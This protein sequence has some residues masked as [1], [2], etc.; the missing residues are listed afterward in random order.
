MSHLNK[1]T[2]VLCYSKVPIPWPRR[3]TVLCH[4]SLRLFIEIEKSRKNKTL[5]ILINN[6][7]LSQIREE[8]RGIYLLGL[9]EQLS[10]LFCPLRQ[11]GTFDNFI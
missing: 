7:I 2:N 10:P 8:D 9:F 4:T 11:A 3:C 6:L 1:E 5:H